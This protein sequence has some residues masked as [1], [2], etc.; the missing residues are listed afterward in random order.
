MAD[1]EGLQ[2]RLDGAEYFLNMLAQYVCDIPARENELPEKR[3]LVSV[4]TEVLR[5]LKN[6]VGI[7]S[8]SFVHNPAHFDEELLKR[9]PVYEKVAIQLLKRLSGETSEINL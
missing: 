9:Y 3:V 6:G 4:I 1:N 2:L 8:S 7:D 5:N